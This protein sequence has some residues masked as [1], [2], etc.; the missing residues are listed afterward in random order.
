MQ[1]I[2]P[3]GHT[4]PAFCGKLEYPH[5]GANCFNIGTGGGPVK[6]AGFREVHFSDYGDVR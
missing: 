3:I 5:P 1:T 6:V 4:R 2:H